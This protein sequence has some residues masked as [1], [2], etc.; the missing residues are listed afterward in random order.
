MAFFQAEID[1]KGWK[2]VL[3]QYLFRNDGDPMAHDLLGRLYAGFLHPMIQL[4]FGIEWQQ[5]VIVAEA[6]AQTAVHENKLGAF[7]EQAE[8]RANERDHPYR[9]LAEFFEELGSGE[10]HRKLATSAHWDDPN[11]IY[12]G[13]MKRAP[14][15]ALDLVS[16]I[17]VQ[18]Q[19]LDERTVEMLHTTAYVAAAAAWHPP[20]IPKFDFFLM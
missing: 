11:R 6:L 5:P 2:A 17:K 15:E 10:Q 16:S 13:V 4:M 19:D 1:S 8:G 7:L 14:D 18:P 3:T 12:D 9:P 20:H